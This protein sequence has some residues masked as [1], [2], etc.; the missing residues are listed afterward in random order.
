MFP[1]QGA[2]QQQGGP[3]RCCREPESQSRVAPLRADWLALRVFFGGG[4]AVDAARPSAMDT[5]LLVCR[6]LISHKAADRGQSARR[7]P[8]TR[9][10]ANFAN[11]R[12]HSPAPW[13]R[14]G[15]QGNDGNKERRVKPAGP[16][17][18][19]RRLAAPVRHLWKAGNE[20]N[21]W[22]PPLQELLTLTFPRQNGCGYL[23]RRE[24]R[25]SG[26]RVHARVHK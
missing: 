7:A 1:L 22:R 26:V 3:L 6:G 24:R 8:R 14:A 25:V 18:A 5:E 10:S 9:H 19:R 16:F 4:Q 20:T 11:R 17:Y 12:L 13:E 21:R 15:P 2:E 23:Q